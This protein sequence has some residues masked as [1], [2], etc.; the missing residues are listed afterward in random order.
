MP[1]RVLSESCYTSCPDMLPLLFMANSFSEFVS[2]ASLLLGKPSSLTIRFLCGDPASQIPKVLTQPAPCF[3]QALTEN[4]C[5]FT[6]THTHT[7]THTC[8]QGH[9]EELQFYFSALNPSCLVHR[10][11]A[12]SDYVIIPN[13]TRHHSHQVLAS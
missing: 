5:T 2:R 6:H 8:S 10:H 13:Q 1:Q 11:C 4:H 12:I 3:T 9:A 7:R